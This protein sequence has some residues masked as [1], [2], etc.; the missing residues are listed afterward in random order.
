[1]NGRPIGMQCCE[2]LLL[3]RIV[4]ILLCKLEFLYLARNNNM[5]NLLSDRIFI[6]NKKNQKCFKLQI[7]MR[8]ENNNKFVTNREMLQICAI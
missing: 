1:M 3:I 5:K 6:F 7:N 8:F 2:P 4:V